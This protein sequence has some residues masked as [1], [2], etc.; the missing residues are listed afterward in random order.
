MSFTHF[1]YDIFQRKVLTES[2][3]FY[4]LLTACNA[5]CE[6]SLSDVPNTKVT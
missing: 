3:T 6:Y 5:A 2:S 1:V 4:I